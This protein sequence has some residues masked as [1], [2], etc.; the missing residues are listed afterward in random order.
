ME[1]ITKQAEMVHK[2][3]GSFTNIA[4]SVA[5]NTDDNRGVSAN[6]V[7]VQRLC[8]LQRE[9]S[10]KV[11]FRPCLQIGQQYGIIKNK[12]AVALQ[13]K[14]NG[15]LIAALLFNLYSSLV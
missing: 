14:L 1:S 9:W 8:F 5:D 13:C 11:S 15:K 2:L 12:A 10:S 7:L 4:I 3:T 6:A